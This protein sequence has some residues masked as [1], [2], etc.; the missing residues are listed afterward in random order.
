MADVLGSFS[1]NPKTEWLTQTGDDRNMKLLEDF[2]YTDPDG[3]VWV[4][5]KGNVVNGASIPAALWST[6]GSP[7]T[8]EYRRAS[9]VHDVACDNP[10]I[11][12]KDADKMFYFACLAGGCSTAQAELLYVG[13]RIG[14]WFPKIRFW[15]EALAS[16]PTITFTHGP[17]SPT[18]TEESVRTTFREISADVQSYPEP[19][20]FNQLERL[21]DQHLAAKAKQ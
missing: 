11:Q 17:V 18:L 19:L 20:S 2:T 6:V 4:A 9:I 5:P 1:D 15:S 12:R 10:A 13:V 8:G 3:K 14:A 21:V 7:Y 16:K